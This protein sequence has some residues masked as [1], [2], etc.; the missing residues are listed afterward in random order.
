[1]NE[2]ETIWAFDLGKASIGEAVRVGHEF[3]HKASL[4]IPA[5][6]A[7]TKPAAGR[8]RMKRTRDAHRERERWLER[9]WKAAGL[10]VVY[11]RN[12][13]KISGEWKAGEAGDE[14]L[15]REFP[16]VGDDTCYTSCLLRIKL[17]GWKEG[18]PELA[19]WQIF[20]ALHSAIQKRGYEKIPWAAKEAR[21][22]GKTEEDLEKEEQK[23]DAN[24]VAALNKWR[25]FNQ[26]VSEAYRFPC[27]YDAWKMGLWNPAQPEALQPRTTHAAESTRNVR[28]DRADVEREIKQL[29]EKANTLLR[30]KLDHARKQLIAEF[31]ADRLQRVRSIN[32]R[33][34]AKNSTRPPERQKQLLIEPSFERLATSVGDFLCHGPTGTSYASFD[35]SLRKGAALRQGSDDDWMGVLGQKIPRFDNRILNDCVL[36]P[37]F[38][39]C[40]AEIRQDR[41]TGKPFPE[42]LLSAE[43]T[44]LMK[45]KNA[46]VAEGDGQRKLRVEE[47]RQVFETLSADVAKVKPD[48]KD[49][50]RKVANCFAVTKAD[51][52]RT[53]GIKELELR[54]RPV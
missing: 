8:R 28:F 20:K 12:C 42:S 45:L 43:V 21:R 9:V 26:A 3:K 36:I 7:D 4:L 32:E 54:P 40:K 22:A 38:H 18:D 29:A 34:R 15:E 48:A 10:E 13:D 23:K 11:G 49:W 39:A 31:K 44:C 33:R 24:Y 52:A 53:K 41:K 35:P 6:F 14:R 25:E 30:G 47:I 1:M 5:E 27:Y 51:W 2:S 50:G 17:L 16:A 19:S 46:L 37:R